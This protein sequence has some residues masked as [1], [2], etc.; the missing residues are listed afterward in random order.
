[1]VKV[2]R[3]NVAALTASWIIF[4]IGSSITTPYYPLYIKALGGSDFHV[5]LVISV[6]RVAE[7]PLII[8]GGYLADIIG[9][10]KLIVTLTWAIAFMFFMYALAPSWEALILIGII[11]SLLLLYRPALHAILIDSL[12]PDVRAKGVLIS[13]IMPNIPWLIF[14]P[15]GGWLADKYGILGYRYAYIIAG[16][17]GVAAAI[18][19]TKF[20]RE[21]LPKHEKKESI[22]KIFINSYKNSISMIKKS[23][24]KIKYLILGSILISGITVSTYTSYAVVFA[25]EVLGISRELWGWYNVLGTISS[26]ILS[27]LVLPFI[28]S[29]P[30]RAVI[31]TSSAIYTSSIYLLTSG[32]G[33]TTVLL[34]VVLS[35]LASTL[36]HPAWQAYIGDIVKKEERGRISAII[37]VATVLGFSWAN[38]L[39]GH[40]YSADPLLA[41]K[42]ALIVGI[43]ETLYWSLVIKEPK[44]RLN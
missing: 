42:M 4:G 10:R 33:Q 24:R 28:D 21:T 14:P 2:L 11:E 6:R 39:M 44:V 8:P 32:M 30:R 15:I 18:L 27:L 40:L 12:P 22:A 19:R 41:F 26:T 38:L 7:I 34:S 37:S 25:S 36:Y 31:V 16:I 3:G 9:R 5:A 29:A 13:T 23:D 17:A 20:L 43:I 1:M 35:T